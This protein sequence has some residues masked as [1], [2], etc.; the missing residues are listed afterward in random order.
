MSS[1]LVESIYIKT[2]PNMPNHP[3]NYPH[4]VGETIFRKPIHMLNNQTLYFSLQWLIDDTH[5]FGVPQPE[6][7]HLMIAHGL[8]KFVHL[9]ICHTFTLPTRL[10]VLTLSQTEKVRQVQAICDARGVE[11]TIENCCPQVEGF[12]ERWID[13]G[14]SFCDGTFLRDGTFCPCCSNDH[15]SYPGDRCICGSPMDSPR[16]RFREDD[17]RFVSENEVV[18]L[19]LQ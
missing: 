17:E 12:N 1:E 16:Y 14:L 8:V 11:F 2:I 5:T 15:V 10:H 6:V 4:S 19:G 9:H 18:P 3:S 13:T 7:V